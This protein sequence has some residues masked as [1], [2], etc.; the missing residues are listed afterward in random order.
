M[1]TAEPCSDAG[2]APPVTLSEFML[3]WDA[4]KDFYLHASN[5]NGF[6]FPVSIES[7]N[8]ACR[9]SSCTANLNEGCRAV[10]EV[11]GPDGAIVGCSSACAAF[12]RPEY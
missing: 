12:N 11:K 4:G 1:G 3:N 7:E 8:S 2:G 5:V 6:N 9:T 10:H